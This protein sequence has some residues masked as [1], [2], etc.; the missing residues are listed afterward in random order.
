MQKMGIALSDAVVNFNFSIQLNQLNIPPGH[1][2]GPYNSG[3]TWKN[4]DFLV[5]SGKTW[6]TQGFF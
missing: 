1:L 5:N 2:T 3:K 4:P 6:K